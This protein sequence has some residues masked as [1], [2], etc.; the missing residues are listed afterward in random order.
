VQGKRKD[1]EE[2]LVGDLEFLDIDYEDFEEEG[3]GKSQMGKITQDVGDLVK[4]N[5]EGYL[6][7]P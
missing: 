7:G 6:I 2:D 1:S 4:H 5:C 3:E